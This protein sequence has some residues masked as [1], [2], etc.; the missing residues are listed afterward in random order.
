MRSHNFTSSN[1]SG[2]MALGAVVRECD[3]PPPPT[4]THTHKRVRALLPLP[5]LTAFR[6]QETARVA[7]TSVRALAARDDLNFR[8]LLPR[9]ASETDASASPALRAFM[10]EQEDQLARVRAGNG[11]VLDLCEGALSASSSRRPTQLIPCI[12]S[13]PPAP[14]H[15]SS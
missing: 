15:T 11:A 8:A 14:P 10:S 5:P 3:P 4:H 2:Q 7:R 6:W 1:S 9:D 12:P 13:P